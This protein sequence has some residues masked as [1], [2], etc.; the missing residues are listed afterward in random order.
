MRT[1]AR[2]PVPAD[3]AGLPAEPDSGL[4]PSFNLFKIEER[5]KSGLG[6]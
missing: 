4:V 6:N 3:D 2:G 5:I 1:F